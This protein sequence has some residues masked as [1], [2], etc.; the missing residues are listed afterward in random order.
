MED[1]VSD[2]SD[3]IDYDGDDGSMAI[4][5]MVEDGVNA[6]MM[7]LQALKERRRGPRR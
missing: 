4:H 2:P 3:S 6:R 1:F 5:Q 7:E